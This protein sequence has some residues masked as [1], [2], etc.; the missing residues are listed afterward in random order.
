MVCAGTCSIDVKIPPSSSSA[1]EVSINEGGFDI[2]CA[3]EDAPLIVGVYESAGVPIH[4]K[5]VV[6][7]DNRRINLHGRWTVLFP[8]LYAGMERCMGSDE[9]P[10]G[11]KTTQS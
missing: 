6:N 1:L 5:S 8:G 10:V 4:D 11:T 3:V 7:A 9:I 2:K